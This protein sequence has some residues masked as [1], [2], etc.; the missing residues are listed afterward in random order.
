[1]D[2]A[3]HPS[4]TLV[5]RLLGQPALLRDGQVLQLLGRHDALLLALLALAGAMPVAR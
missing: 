3:D 1:M 4:P 5:I 2:P